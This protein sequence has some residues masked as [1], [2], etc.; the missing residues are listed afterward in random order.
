LPEHK[1]LTREVW[2]RLLGPFSREVPVTYAGLVG[3]PQAA[4]WAKS[5][6]GHGHRSV[7]AT[8]S[9]AVP[10]ATVL[11]AELE[12]IKRSRRVR[13]E[14]GRP[15][16]DEVDPYQRAGNSQLLALA[17]SGGGIRSATFNLG[18][19]QA[20][21]D[22]KLLSR[23]DYLSAVSGGGYIGSWLLAWIKRGDRQGVLDALR[24]DRAKRK[25]SCEPP[26]IDFLR[27]YSNY[28]TPRVGL[29]GADTWAAIGIYLRNTSLNLM[30][31]IPA[32][33]ALLL[34]PR[35]SSLYFN[36][37]AS[38]TYAS[39][40]KVAFVLLSVAFMFIVANL[41]D[42][43]APTGKAATRKH[44]PESKWVFWPIVLPI[45]VSTWWLGAWLWAMRDWV[46]THWVRWIFFCG[47]A[48]FWVW[49]M[50]SLVG[51]VFK[52]LL[53]PRPH[54]FTG[55]V[56]QVRERAPAITDI[57]RV[58]VT[59]FFS[60]VFAGALL[61]ALAAWMGQ[62]KSSDIL[63]IRYLHAAHWGVPLVIL[64]FL[65]AETL[66]IGLADDAFSEEAREW[67]G[68]LGGLLLL[69]SLGLSAFFALAL[70]GPW[71]VDR[72]EATKWIKPGL[73]LSWLATTGAGLLAGRSPAT[74]APGSRRILDWIGKL[75]PPVFAVGLL[76]LL[77]V[78]LHGAL[79]DIFNV[80]QRAFLY[81]VALFSEPNT[82]PRTI[83]VLQRALWGVKAPSA[84]PPWYWG[85]LGET[86]V[87]CLWLCALGALGLSSWI[88]HL[89]SINNFSM[90]AFYRNR[91]VRCYLGA[92]RPKERRP[93]PFT[94]FDPDDD[95]IHLQDLKTEKGYAGP[96]PIL[97]TALNLVKGEQ[98]AWQ[99]RKA[100]SFAFTPL[101]VGYEV[102]A[103]TKKKANLS[104]AGY[105]RT[106]KYSPEV[107]LGTAMA[108][109]G[110]AA[111]PNMGY[112][113]SRPLAF[114]MT[115]FNV[116]LGWWFGNPRHNKSWKSPRPAWGLLYLLFELL[117]KTD[118]T[119]GYV[120]LSDGGHFENLGI[121]ELV[122]R[123]CRF[124]MACD[125]AEDRDM[126]FGDLGNAIEKC[127]TDFGVDIEIDVERLRRQKES[128]RS[129]RH[130]VV[131]TIH[132]E[133]SHPSTPPGTLVYLK[134]S[135]TGDEPTD[136]LRYAAQNPEFPHQPTANQW[137]N[138]SQFESYRMLG[139]HIVESLFGPVGKS[140][141]LATMD[142]E[143]LFDKLR[144]C[145]RQPAATAGV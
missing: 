92:A 82:L 74:G 68:R 55:F 123:R 73:L 131:G 89:V 145:R 97:N 15:V 4:R 84:G 79:A 136:V 119:R 122:R 20:L 50:A 71:L 127:R 88:S 87:G 47:W 124:I 33:A 8:E 42:L 61:L 141:E 98:L 9:D 133:K 75:A 13:C 45:L 16:R 138:E 27:Q 129:W 130:G 120:Y 110:A 80:L 140:D 78:L 60:G 70:D 39:G 49:V 112:H 41:A 24:P 116:R 54:P 118:D 35:I 63:E 93:H 143:M 72:L 56:S 125:A 11:D 48:Y 66:H 59:A 117:G 137:F 2:D 28:L 65:L 25:E 103:A 90:H 106:E 109:S 96:Y 53:E 36:E 30:I 7:E 104:H 57:G 52:W 29:F 105:R 18:V 26:E 23:F 114:L 101:G 44:Y 64:V 17:F 121:Y 32:L 107:S 22:L 77:A 113:S 91:L 86:F 139:Q 69:W 40:P 21:A 76:L 132:Y 1:G 94:G 134:S 10:F 43:F 31:L 144:D 85:E 62:W 111:S 115:V 12:E 99:Q 5:W 83:S 6:H 108:I 38:R 128:H 14:S 51:G 58:M 142:L 67:W 37:F 34:L 81:L 19:L 102:D 100:A 135:L 126:K 3:D 95:R 46:T